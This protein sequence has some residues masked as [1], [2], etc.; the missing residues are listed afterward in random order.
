MHL[1]RW[2]IHAGRKHEIGPV[3]SNC[4]CSIICS[5]STRS[6]HIFLIHIVCTYIHTY[7]SLS[8]LSINQ[9]IDKNF[10]EIK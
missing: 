5:I 6:Y 7:V 4:V 1:Y 10:I 8:Q 3:I 2:T 9:L